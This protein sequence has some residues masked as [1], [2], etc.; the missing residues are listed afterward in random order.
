MGDV[1]RIVAVCDAFGA[2]SFE[3]GLFGFML[4]RLVWIC[5]RWLI[6]LIFSCGFG[7]G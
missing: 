3:C 7:V 4:L 6:V 1:F 2:L 5:F